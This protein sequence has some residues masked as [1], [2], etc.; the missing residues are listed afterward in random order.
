MNSCRSQPPR[1]LKRRSVAAC[2]L[3]L[4]VRITPGTWM[5]V[6]CDCCVV[7]G[8]GSLR[9]ANHLSRGVLPTGVRRWV[10]SRNLVDEEALAHC[11][12]GGVLLRQIKKVHGFLMT[13]KVIGRCMYSL[14]KI[15]VHRLSRNAFFL[16]PSHNFVS[17]TLQTATLFSHNVCRLAVLQW[18][19][20]TPMSST[21]HYSSSKAWQDIF[22]LKV[23]F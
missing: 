19:L 17:H 10:W 6:C 13:E 5:F 20:Y 2:L 9:R 1:G 23:S 14:S 22:Y 18:L 11:R 16:P 15:I 7:S 8:R 4:W 12:G 21:N 3:R